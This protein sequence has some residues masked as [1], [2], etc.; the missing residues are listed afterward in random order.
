MV[1]IARLC[2]SILRRTTHQFQIRK[3]SLLCGDIDR[4]NGV[5]IDLKTQLPTTT[6]TADFHKILKESLHVWKSEGRN[7][8]WLHLPIDYGRY[9]DIA[10]EEGF[11]FH[12]AE[13]NECL[14]KLWLDDREDP[15][16]RFAT[17]QLGVCGVVLR[18]DTQE[19]LVIQEKKSQFTT[20]KFPGGLA[21]LGE[22]IG[23]AAIRETLEETGVQTEF[24]SVIAF[25]QQHNHPSA[26]G[27]SDLYVVCRLRP[28]TF[29]IKPCE[30]EILQCCWMHVDELR[31]HLQITSLTHRISNIILYGLKHGF[32]SI[33]FTSEDMLSPY[34]GQHFTAFHRNL[35]Q[36]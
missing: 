25:R 19:L 35:P 11:Q 16:P 9:I 34:K 18:E 10:A 12:N 1:A 31:E 2:S 17:H 13:N 14:L 3:H 4:F 7:A 6:S 15:T 23:N 36:L 32:D 26:F 30:H 29:D 22:D 27:R 8:I 33:D 21:D 5:T 28:L 24:A 20:W